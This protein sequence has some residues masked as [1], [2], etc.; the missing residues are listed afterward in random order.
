MMEQECDLPYLETDDFQAVDMPYGDGLFSMTV[1]LPKP[2]TSVNELI[3]EFTPENWA[4]WMGS[5]SEATLTLHMPK[6]KL[7]YEDSLNRV[8]TT[9]G[10]GIAFSD[11]ADFTRI[12]RNG[13]LFISMV[14][15]KSFVEVDE[16]GTEAAAVTVVEIR[17]TSMGPV[18]TVDR[19]FVFV[20]RERQ[21]NALLFMGK[22]V[23]PSL[24]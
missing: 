24:E 9:L 14:K 10:M 18:M 15:H 2:E 5:F 8:L 4:Q 23:E 21:S 1:F 3:E 12:N 16:E 22:I 6:F 19:P 17:Y 11:Q 7:E 20:I 13:G